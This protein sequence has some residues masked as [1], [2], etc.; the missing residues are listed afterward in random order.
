MRLINRFRFS[1]SA[2]F[3]I[4]LIASSLNIFPINDVSGK[5]ITD[6]DNVTSTRVNEDYG[7]LPLSFIRNDGQIDKRVMFYEK[8]SGHATFFSKE[9]V[10]I[11]LKNDLVKLTFLN[12]N[13]SPEIVA[14]NQQSGKVNYFTGNNPSKWKTNIPTFSSVLYKEVYPGIDIKFYGNNSQME[15]DIIVQPGA[16]P[17]KVNFSYDGIKDLKVTEGGDLEIVLNHGSIIQKS[18]V[19]YQDIE[20]ERV[21]VKGSFKIDK[22]SYRFELASYH[23]DFPLVIDPVLIYSTYVGGSNNEEIRDI[24]VDSSGNV[25]VTGDTYS[26][27]FPV[28]SAIYGTNAG[29]ADAFVTKI[30]ASGTALIYSTYIGG[31]AYERGTRLFVDPSGSV[32]V[33]GQTASTDFP[34]VSP[35]QSTN[36]GGMHDAFVAKIDASGSS[37][38]YSTYL[39]GGGDDLS[40]GIA[41]DAAGAIYVA[42][43][44]SSTDF[45]TFAPIQGYNG[46]LYDVFVTKLN[47]SGSAFV[48]S[49]Y[50]GGSSDDRAS[51][52]SLDTSGNAYITGETSSVDYPTVSAIQG[53]YG[54]GFLDAF[55]TKVNASGSAL[56]FS[57]YI[58]GSGHEYGGGITLDAAG[59]IYIAGLTDS[60]DFPVASPLQGSNAGWDD[61][62]VTKMDASGSTL[63]YSTY[64]GGT[65]NEY[66]NRIAVDSAGAAYI[67]GGTFSTDFPAF[68]F[69]RWACGS[70]PTY[71]DAFVTKI[72]PS[73]SGI[74]YYR[75]IGGSDND[76][77]RG[78]AVDSAGNAYVGGVTYSPDFPRVTALQSG[79]PGCP[80]NSQGFVTKV[81]TASSGD[82]DISPA[83]ADQVGTSVAF[84]GTNYLVVWEDYRSGVSD[85]YGRLFTTS[86]IPV[87]GEFV[88]SSTLYEKIDT[89][90]Y[91]GGGYYLVVWED[92]RNGDSDVYGQIVST[93]GTLSG[94]EFAISNNPGTE[95]SMPA[96]GFDGTNYLV[97]WEDNRYGTFD[98]WGRFITTSGT[99][100]GSRFAISSAS[101]D[102]YQPQTKFDGTRYLVVWPED[103]TGTMDV[104][105]QFVSTSGSLAGG[106]I[107]VSTAVSTM[108]GGPYSRVH[109]DFDGTNYFVVWTDFRNGTRQDIY[110]QRLTSAGALLGTEIAISTTDSPAKRTRQVLFNGSN[111]YLVIWRDGVS[112]EWNRQVRAQ[113]VTTAGVLSGSE[114]AISTAASDQHGPSLAF[115][116]TNYLA[117][118]TDN[119]NGLYG[120]PY[121]HFISGTAPPS[122]EVCDGIDNDL[123][124]LI[125]E[126]FTD[127]DSDGVA[128]CVDLD[129]DNDGMSDSWEV[130]YGLNP[131]NPADAGLDG[132]TDGFTNLEEFIG[133]T[134]PWNPLDV[135]VS[136]TVFDGS[137]QP[138]RLVAPPDATVISFSWIDPATLPPSA[139]TFPYGLVSLILNVPIPGASATVALTFPGVVDTASVY[140]K[141]GPTSINPTNHWYDFSYGSN[142]GDATITLTL[143]DGGAGD[144]DLIANGTIDDPGGPAMLPVITDNDNDGWSPP[145]DCND[146]DNTIFPGAT[147]I[148]GD[149]IDQ[150]CSGADSVVASKLA[151]ISTRGMVQTGDSVMIG[152]FIISGSAPR[153]VLIRG[154]GPTLADFGVTG[155]MANPYVELYSGQTLI[156]T[157]DNWQTPIVQCDA[158]A[159]SCGTPQDIQATGKD[160][161]T[162]ATTGCSQDAAILV[163]LPPGAYTAIMRGVGGGTGVGLIGVDDNDISP[164]SKLVNIS[165]RGPVLTGDSVMIGGFIVGGSSSKTVLIRGFGPTLSDFG[166]TGALVDPYIELYSGQTMIATNDNWQTQQCDAP[167]VFCGTP[168]DIQATGKDACTVATTGCS[169]DAALLVTLPPGAYTAIVRGVGG[170]TGV[171]LVGIDEIGP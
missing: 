128:D 92:Y 135:P 143:T 29:S 94:S 40:R 99:L 12:A 58:G 14:L 167:T 22:S 19:I 37:L 7:K 47:A 57:T 121:G 56:V 45:P 115:D 157:N 123:D 117:G 16:D 73:G 23:K 6:T 139:E 111:R 31:S 72:N 160:A 127:T 155:A 105:G 49:T 122:A 88:I 74:D 102:Q 107:A 161:C 137:M 54:G 25:Y 3:V 120:K 32:Y 130:P 35:V 2:V 144:H 98:I 80:T 53:V 44:T 101:G 126:G 162:V 112:L 125:D 71:S 51:Y 82:I 26:T 5:E 66:G 129:D 59:D 38:A 90:V 150:D 113:F 63:V 171:G 116:G 96:I 17:A 67:T 165:T 147:D 93:S 39:G 50:V 86:G 62:F 136:L 145:S 118:W 41:V 42:G 1:W 132:D 30:D 146:N 119:R 159:V 20:G 79:C 34:T 60:T 151:N 81:S 109:L 4:V 10:S 85:I 148:P 28:A 97:V 11:S 76:D 134:D 36:S 87:G 70:C 15:Y 52:L 95:Q 163:T 64:L 169:Q 142:N 65:G 124:S 170:L 103:R 114:I 153:S 91:F 61:V 166:V 100:A 55:V 138:I 18:P 133:E 152:G 89:K 164:L 75:Y 77:G 104:Y 68:P 46:G 156:A 158:P 108:P 33:S 24:K 168:E 13:K 84:D 69:I 8:G 21:P 149:G 140:K 141:Y 78:I 110:G 43:R 48:Y 9:G 27:D 131:V 106:E 83:M 154:F